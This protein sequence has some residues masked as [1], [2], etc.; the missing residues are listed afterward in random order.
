MV[1]LEPLCTN[2]Q[3]QSVDNGCEVNIFERLKRPQVRLPCLCTLFFC[4]SVFDF[5][6][7]SWKLFKYSSS[8]WKWLPSIMVY[9]WFVCVYF[10]ILFDFTLFSVAVIMLENVWKREKWLVYWSP[11]SFKHWMLC[12][13]PQFHKASSCVGLLDSA[14]SRFFCC[15][16]VCFCVCLFFQHLIDKLRFRPFIPL[17]GQCH[18]LSLNQQT[19]L[20][21]LGAAAV[22]SSS[23]YLQ[24]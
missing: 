24:L 4:I 5:S 22:L 20:V 8:E 18:R 19:L 13:Q 12:F 17:T 2:G 11:S 15:F 6:L 3:M 9:Y 21:F 16:F 1:H 23:V 14:S 10:L 7:S